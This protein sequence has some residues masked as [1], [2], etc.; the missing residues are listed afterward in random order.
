MNKL[1]KLSMLSISMMTNSQAMQEL[2]QERDLEYEM[3]YRENLSKTA[4]INKLREESDG[5]KQLYKD[6]VQANDECYA[7]KQRLKEY[8]EQKL[9]ENSDELA[10]LNELIK[11]LKFDF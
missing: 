3:E 7:E 5:W 8:Y 4:L 1:L 6:C 9:V 2:Y 10:K 11:K